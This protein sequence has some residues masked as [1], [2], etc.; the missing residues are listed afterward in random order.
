MSEIKG[1][2]LDGSS[3]GLTWDFVDDE[4]KKLG[5][6]DRSKFVQYCIERVIHRRRLE[7]RFVVELIILCLV[8]MSFLLLLMIF[9]GV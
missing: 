9:M 3:S 7:K 4:A 2:S 5:F 1:I 8:T 6:N